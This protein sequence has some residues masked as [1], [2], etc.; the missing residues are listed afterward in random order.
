MPSDR[1]TTRASIRGRVSPYALTLAVLPTSLVG[2]APRTDNTI[3]R[4]AAVHARPESAVS[5]AG[6]SLDARVFDALGYVRETLDALNP[7][8]EIFFSARPRNIRRHVGR[9]VSR[10]RTAG[11]T[12]VVDHIEVL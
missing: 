12:E 3:S 2:A 4:P 7:P 11:L 8:Q 9:V 10:N 5:R 1:P 6:A